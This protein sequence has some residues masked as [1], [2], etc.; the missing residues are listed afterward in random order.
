MATT[1]TNMFIYENLE[2][3]LCQYITL[4]DYAIYQN[5]FSVSF[6]NNNTNIVMYENLD[7]MLCQ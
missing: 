5:I 3:V 1:Q 6:A 2:Y 7:Y 4:T